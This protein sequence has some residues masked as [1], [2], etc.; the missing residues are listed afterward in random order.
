MRVSIP[1]AA[2][3][4]SNGYQSPGEGGDFSPYFV[5]IDGSGNVWVA[6]A[7]G[8]LAE[9]VGA[10]VPVVTPVVANL[11]SPYGSHAVNK[12]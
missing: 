7:D 12:P 2:I 11:L 1:A 10:A 3:S 9:F 5:A 6:N 4:G 8:N